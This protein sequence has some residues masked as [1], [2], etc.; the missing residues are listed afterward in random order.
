MDKTW[1]EGEGGFYGAC[2]TRAHSSWEER[3][4]VGVQVLRAAQALVLGWESV[5]GALGH[6][7]HGRTLLRWLCGCLWEGGSQSLDL[8]RSRG[9]ELRSVELFGR[10]PAPQ[11]SPASAGTGVTA[12]RPQEQ[13]Q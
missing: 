9:T 11:V 3:W 13:G 7:C 12:G 1:K 6:R 10:D 8:P 5:E 4:G 2:E